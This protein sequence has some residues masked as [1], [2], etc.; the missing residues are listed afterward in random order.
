MEVDA[1]EDQTRTTMQRDMLGWIQEIVAC[2]IRRPGSPG[3]LA[4]EHLLER[5]FS[6][7]GL[8]DVRREP[9]P[10]NH[11]APLTAA[12]HFVDDRRHVP[13]FSVP[14]TA[15]TPAGGIEA[16]LVYLSAGTAA[17]FDA[18]DVSGKVAVV[19]MRFGQLSGAALMAGSYFMNDP[20]QTIPA[21]PLHTANWLIENFAAYYAAHHRGAAAFIGLLRDSPID[22]P[23]QYI[24]Y[25]G[26]LKNLPGVWI[27]REW[28]DEVV[29]GCR[30]GA[31]VFVESA[32]KTELVDS[33]N[34]VGTVVGTGAES[35]VVSCHHDAPFASA[36]EDASGLAVLLWLA[37]EFA[38]QPGHPSRNLVFVASS[39]HFHGG[40]GNRVFV[41]RH[42]EGFLQRTVAALG[43]EHI[44]EEAESDGQG[45]YRLTGRPEVRA[46]FVDESPCLVRLLREGV[47]R[48][49]LDRTIAVQAYL[50]G[51]EPPCDTAPFFTAGIPSV[52]HI[53]GPLYLF[54]PHDTID[55]VRADDLPR[56]AGF[57]AELIR[58]LDRI[59]AAEL[60]AGLTRRRGDPPAAHPPWFLPPEAYQKSTP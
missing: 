57:F 25:D 48:W 60:E 3:G 13:C 2:G 32:G 35:I 53:S 45:G 5:K 52:C 55:K 23:L 8:A 33:H 51:P 43:I 36:V 19:D 15:W 24:P 10:V 42:R 27:G 38:A 41:E 18:V 58:S 14:Y 7:F 20:G 37:R 1:I 21:G 34:V 30:L 6:E 59:P 46:L 16:E 28:A 56:V 11:W 9:V 12:V 17:D 26:Y 44:A 39:G 50:F 47:T 40:V 4:T 22:G 31:R 49:E 29:Q 54:D